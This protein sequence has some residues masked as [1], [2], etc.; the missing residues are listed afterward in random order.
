MV[1]R[2]LAQSEDLVDRGWFDDCGSSLRND[3]C[4]CPPIQAC[5]AKSVSGIG[6]LAI[7]AAR[8]PYK[9]VRFGRS[10]RSNVLPRVRA[11]SRNDSSKNGFWP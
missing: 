8:S 3:P 5:I 7:D 9:T 2:L 11:S 4:R 1:R 6:P 10:T